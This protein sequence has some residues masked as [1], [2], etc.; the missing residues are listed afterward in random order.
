MRRSPRA[1]S[2]VRLTAA[3]SR[4]EHEPAAPEGEATMGEAIMKKLQHVNLLAEANKADVYAAFQRDFN[5]DTW[6]QMVWR[7]VMLACAIGA[8][9]V[10]KHTDWLWIFGAI[11]AAEQSLAWFVDNSNRNWLMHAIDWYEG[12][13]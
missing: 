10:S 1:A 13:R 9:L 4:P 7:F 12:D 8:V 3:V 11:Y 5:R 6:R 2:I